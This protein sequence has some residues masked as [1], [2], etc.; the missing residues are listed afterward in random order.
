MFFHIGSYTYWPD[1]FFVH[2]FFFGFW[3]L[4]LFES[5]D[6]HAIKRAREVQFL[7]IN[8]NIQMFKCDAEKNER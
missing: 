8:S 2:I 7:C 3:F 5:D 6:V 1:G 4:G